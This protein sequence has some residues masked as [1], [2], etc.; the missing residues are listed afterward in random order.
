MVIQLETTKVYEMPQVAGFE[1]TRHYLVYCE[2]N[3]FLQIL[4]MKD[5]RLIGIC[6]REVSRESFHLRNT[7]KRVTDE[8]GS[9]VQALAQAVWVTEKDLDDPVFFSQK[10][11]PIV[12]R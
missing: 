8:R 6:P 4:Q 5:N 7:A 12:A 1:H 2:K 10:K 9:R 3:E 11:H